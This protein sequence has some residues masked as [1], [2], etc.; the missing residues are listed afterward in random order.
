M[1]VSL[2]SLKK[3]LF[4]DKKRLTVAQIE[5]YF[6]RWS[7]QD[8]QKK[9]YITDDELRKHFVKRE[10]E[11]NKNDISYLNALSNVMG[12]SSIIGKIF[13]KYNIRYKSFNAG[14]QKPNYHDGPDFIDVK[15]KKYALILK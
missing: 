15:I 1:Q 6:L 8:H 11:V 12:F 4:K 9:S 5:G 14:Y 10:L 13:K 3:E 2:E 7:E